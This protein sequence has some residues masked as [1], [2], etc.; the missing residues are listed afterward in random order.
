M[1]LTKAALAG[2]PMRQIILSTQK[3]QR[4]VLGGGF[5][6]ILN[7]AHVG[8]VHDDGVSVAEQ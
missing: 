4:V 6:L 2:E 8:E 1:L 3:T 7:R 5:P